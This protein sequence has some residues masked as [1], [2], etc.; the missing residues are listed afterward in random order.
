M[1]NSR[2]RISYGLRSPRLHRVPGPAPWCPTTSFASTTGAPNIAETI[3]RN[4]SRLGKLFARPGI[5]QKELAL[6]ATA[7]EVVTVEFFW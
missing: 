5:F 7:R 4:S 1:L 3:R 6:L 2:G